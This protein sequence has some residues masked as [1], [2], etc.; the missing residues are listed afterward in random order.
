MPEPVNDLGAAWCVR[1]RLEMRIAYMASKLCVAVAVLGAFAAYSA[2][3]PTASSV[4]SAPSP[5]SAELS[6]AFWSHWGDGRA[7]MNAYR[8]VQPRYAAPRKGT[9]VLIYVT[10]DFS[11]RLR[12]KADPGKHP[13]SD[14][15]P[16]LKLNAI[17]DFQTGIY[18]YNV[19]TSVFAR[20]DAGWPIAKVSFSS[21]EWCGHVYHQLLPRGDSV[22]GWSHSYFDGEADATEK[23][24]MPA[25][26]VMEDALPILLRGWAG[27]YL[28]PGGSATVPF[29]PSLLRARLEH[30]PLAWG[31]ATI[32][33]TADTD[34]VEVPAGRFEVRTWT[35]TPEDGPQATYQIEA[36][37]PHRL[38]R[39]ATDAGE[40]AELRGSERLAYW[41]LNGPGG[42]ESLKRLG[43]QP[44][45][46]A[47]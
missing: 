38:V 25:R 18:D 12:V 45:T 13:P 27:A 6:R 34:E 10:E 16:V 11:D 36:A 24:S 44:E 26:G 37:S 3:A 2:S 21:Q 29:L 9:A 23:L 28:S 43:L 14:V 31:R 17:R 42:E 22:T 33:L 4:P 1:Y 46:G 5:L 30:R 40:L 39:W 35:V 7:E 15:Y 47:W 32:A 20:V 41:K 19:M 8:L